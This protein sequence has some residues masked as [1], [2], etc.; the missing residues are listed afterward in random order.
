[1]PDI[2]SMR[3]LTSNVCERT[4]PPR[5]AFVITVALMDHSGVSLWSLGVL[6]VGFFLVLWLHPI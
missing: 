3:N 1:M 5:G 2:M 6:C 4:N